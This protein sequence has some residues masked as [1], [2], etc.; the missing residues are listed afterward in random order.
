MAY[1]ETKVICYQ[2]SYIKKNLNVYR[3]TRFT[4]LIDMCVCARNK[5]NFKF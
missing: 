4:E 5:Y 2:I 1:D 3:V